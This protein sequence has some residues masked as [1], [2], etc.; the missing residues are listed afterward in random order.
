MKH[1][2]VWHLVKLIQGVRIA[3]YKLLSSCPTKGRPRLMQPTLMIG[4]GLI[5]FQ[6]NVTLGYYPSPFFLNGYSH[7]E[8]RSRD[9]VISIG[10]G[11]HI[12][13][14]FVAIAEHTHITIG[15]RC[16]IGT[17]V[18]MSDSDFHGIKVSERG[19]SSY[20]AARAVHIGDD[21]FIGSNVKILKGSVIGN[22]SVIANGA[23]VA[24]EIPPNVIAGGIPAKVLKTIAL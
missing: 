6:G 23:I 7:L 4:N 8:A 24:G 9:C 12:N 20:K 18:E 3:F 2:I 10:E 16:L 13:N 1:S 17:Q 15:K 21:V 19:I 11:T 22:G 14:N 5:A